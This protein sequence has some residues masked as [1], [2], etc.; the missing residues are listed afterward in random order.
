MAWAHPEFGSLI[1]VACDRSILIFEETS[2][3]QGKNTQNGWVKRSPPLSDARDSITD[4]KVLV[5]SYSRSNCY[6]KLFIS[7]NSL[8]RI[9]QCL[10]YD[11][12]CHI[13]KIIAVA[14]FF[15]FNFNR[16]PFKKIYF[17]LNLKI[18]PK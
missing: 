15:N 13:Y 2:Y 6:L 14:N 9:L 16:S 17:H 4:L 5:Y 7:E 10:I 11:F 3:G 18:N 12:F 1:A 8:I